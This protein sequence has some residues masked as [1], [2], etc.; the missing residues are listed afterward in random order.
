M[1]FRSLNAGDCASAIT[2]VEKLYQSSSSDDQVRRLRASAHGCRVGL[3]FLQKI[4]DLASSDLATNG[5]WRAITQLFPSSDGDNR[6]ESS[7]FATDAL[8]AWLKPGVVVFD[9]Y[10]LSW[11]PFNP[12]SMRVTDLTLDSNIYLVLASMATIGTLHNRHGAP[13]GVGAPTQALPWVSISRMDKEGC[14]YVS[15]ILTMNDALAEVGTTISQL[16][17]L[18]TAMGVAA[19][20]FDAACQM[21][22]TACGLVCSSCP[23]T[24]RHRSS[25]DRA[26]PTTVDLEGCAAAG[27]V[28]NF[29]N[30]AVVGWR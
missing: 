3:G 27:L 7:F 8:Q 6:V 26:L 17:N 21:G 10:R 30:N 16:S 5:P 11:D 4:E 9:P 15:A 2:E 18:T 19:T 23:T 20:G 14:G 12:G 1:L 24:L 22:C 25:C 28:S 13:D 29:M